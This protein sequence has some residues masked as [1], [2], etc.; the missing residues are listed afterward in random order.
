MRQ[1]RL[2]LFIAPFGA[3]L[4]ITDACEQAIQRIDGVKWDAADAVAE[5]P[6]AELPWFPVFRFVAEPRCETNFCED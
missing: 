1:P 3:A 2:P 4:H 5:S 6:G